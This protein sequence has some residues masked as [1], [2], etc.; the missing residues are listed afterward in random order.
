MATF[1]TDIAVGE[2]LILDDGRLTITLESKGGRKARIKLD[3]VRRLIVGKKD[4]PKELSKPPTAA[5][6]LK[7]ND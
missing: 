5:K 6:R 7:I 4:T 3:C 2:P 1:Y